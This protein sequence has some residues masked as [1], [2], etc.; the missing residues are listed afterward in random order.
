MNNP[1]LP[2]I[3]L[4]SAAILAAAAPARADVIP[5]DRSTVWNP[6]LNAVGGIPY[7]TTIF[8]TL[9]PSG[10]DDTAAI[11]AVLD[12]CPSNQVVLLGAGTFI[13]SDPG[14][15]IGQSGVTLRGAGPD[16]TLLVQQTNAQYPVVIIGWRW[17][18]HTVS[19]P[20]TADGVK[21]TNSVAIS[22]ATGLKVGEIVTLNQLS[23]DTRSDTVAP[24][25]K[26]YWGPS[27]PD[28]FGGVRRWFCEQNRPIGQTL[29]I[30]AING[31]QLTFST[32][33]H[34]GFETALQAGL[35]RF[36]LDE[37]DDPEGIGWN[38]LW[39]DQVDA[40]EY[41]GIEDLAVSWGNG[42]DGGGNIHFWDCA[43]CWVR[44]VESSYS[45]GHSCNL[46]SSFRCEVRDSC[47]HTTQDPNPGGAGYGIGVNVYA[48]DNL[49][50]NNIVWGFNKMTIGRAS[51]G[52]N[53]FGYN[54]LQDGFGAGYLAIVETGAGANH[55][56]GSHMELFEGNEGF[57]CDSESRWGNCI[58]E[59][60]FRNRW[61]GLRISMPPLQLLDYDARRMVGVDAH[62][63]WHS[64]AGNV[65]GFPGMPL[66]SGTD[67]QFGYGHTQIGF[68]YQA[69]AAS[70]AVSTSIGQLVPAWDIG[71]GSDDEPDPLA[72][73]RTYR[74]GNYDYV[75]DSIVWDPD[76]PDHA[77]PDSLYLAA[78][79][80]FFGNN[81]WPWVTPENAPATTAVLP[82][83][84]RFNDIQRAA[85][86]TYVGWM[87][88][89]F[90]E[91]DQ[92]IDAVSGP[93]ADPDAA[94]LPN[95]ARYAFGLAPRGPVSAPVTP[96]TVA[97][98]GRNYLTIA[99]NRRV[100]ATDISYI[101]EG[102]PDLAN[103]SNIATVAPGSP[104]S[105]TVPDT[106]PVSS[107]A[108]RFL[109]LEVTYAP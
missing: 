46:E 36:S 69:D 40:V 11:Q 21:G 79:P 103:W 15:A 23:D 102:S 93:G 75:T 44:N 78:K 86:A 31:N 55:Y 73:A 27:A 63:W 12:A 96:G 32:P 66:L 62:A 16:Q 58:Y 48:S 41:S 90:S 7:R 18:K 29:E 65:L 33:L 72:L 50:E 37:H 70:F 51:G 98:G 92:F 87:K 107:A 2:A 14:L 13:I 60:I 30:Q 85:A 49:Y 8:Q 77:L 43:Y 24:V 64:F 76:N 94:G 45:S 84:V 25:R 82:A 52:G 22:D 80:A 10:S 105:V 57:N 83:K 97:S 26:V 17:V 6:G 71:H 100:A 104:S 91:T 9:S 101:V 19:H 20:L 88:A 99:F 56:A 67:P 35:S 34:I 54:Y 106:A 42:G 61:T 108:R 28:P 89:S 38:A 1:R 47:F 53:V 59:T 3:L 68:I 5:S 95:V 4:L 109:R 39:T 74:H 81:P